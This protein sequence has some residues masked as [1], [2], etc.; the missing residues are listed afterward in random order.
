[1]PVWSRCHATYVLADGKRPGL[2]RVAE[3]GAAIACEVWELSAAAFGSF[4]AAIP[5]P[6]DIGS[7]LLEDGSSVSG[8]VCEPAGLDGA[9]DITALGGWRAYLATV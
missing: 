2:I 4:V 7:V 3:G 6:L 1:M 5:A 8:F 9:R